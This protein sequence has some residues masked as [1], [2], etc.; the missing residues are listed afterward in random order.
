MY[1][2]LIFVIVSLLSRTFYEELSLVEG[3]LEGFC[4]SFLKSVVGFNVYTPFLTN[5][6][7]GMKVLKEYGSS[8]LSNFQHKL[9]D[10][11][12]V[13]AHYRS[14]KV[15]LVHWKCCGTWSLYSEQY[16]HGVT[17][18]KVSS[19]TLMKIT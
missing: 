4:N 16:L 10:S 7:W 9:G 15:R 13:I 18:V 12:S 1:L 6:E 8:F 14:L 5:M 3:S 11:L 19:Y 2:L 17:L